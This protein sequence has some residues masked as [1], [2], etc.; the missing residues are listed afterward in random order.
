MAK[1][2]KADDVKDFLGIGKRKT[3]PYPNAP[4]LVLPKIFMRVKNKKE[5]FWSRTRRSRITTL[6][7]VG[8]EGCFEEEPIGHKMGF[9]V[10]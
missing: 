10:S 4:N 1:K 8:P 2:Q 6:F 3:N 5:L 9:S 7:L